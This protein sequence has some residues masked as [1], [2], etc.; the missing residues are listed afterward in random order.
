[1]ALL[2]AESTGKTTLSH[3]LAA[4][5]RAEGHA[6][7]VVPERLRAWCEAAGRAPT[8][9]EH[10]AI[11]QAQDAAIDAAAAGGARVVLADTTGLLAALYGG[12]AFPG[13]PTWDHGLRWLRGCE[14]VLLAGLDL[15]WTADG[16]QRAG[17]AVRAQVDAQLRAALDGA[18]I[19]YR[20]VYGRGEARLRN[21]LAPVQ[22]LLGEARHA[23]G[24]GW[25]HACANCGDPACER[26]LFRRLA[27]A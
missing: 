24:G 18:G 12:L 16:L 7:A 23:A 19:A 27:G 26:R 15:P 11:A 2:G 10:R 5:L 14:L 8:P 21:A 6:V 9:E 22:A 13:D 20:V 17:P 3:A 4:A 1:V 25:L